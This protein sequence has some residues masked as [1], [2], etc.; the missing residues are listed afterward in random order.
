ME[1]LSEDELRQ[2]KINNEK[3]HMRNISAVFNR[4]SNPHIIKDTLNRVED[5]IGVEIID[6]YKGEP[7]NENQISYTFKIL[8]LSEDSIEEC[9]KILKGFGGTTR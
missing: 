9:I 8:S 6:I 7:I 1:V 5:I 3:I 4:K 2:W